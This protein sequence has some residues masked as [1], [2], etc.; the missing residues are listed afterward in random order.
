M[1][2]RHSRD[3]HRETR[4][5]L[6]GDPVYI[7]GSIQENTEADR[8]ASELERL[9]LKPSSSLKSPNL[10]KRIMLGE[11]KK[12]R[13]TDIYDVFFLSDLTEFKVKDR[14]LFF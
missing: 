3:S 2:I 9:I 12:T 10:F 11:D 14:S 8:D 5:L 4:S 6:P 13:G 1:W 7:I